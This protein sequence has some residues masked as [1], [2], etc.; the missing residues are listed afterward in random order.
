MNVLIAC[1]CSGI[2]RDAF[3]AKGHIAWSCDLF[4]SYNQTYYHYQGDVTEILKE[5]YLCKCG[6]IFPETF[7]KYGCCSG[8]AKLLTWD[9]LIAFPPCTHLSVSGAKHFKKKI[10]RQ[11]KAID[12]FMQMVTAPIEKI[13]IENPVGIMSTIYRKPDQIIQPYM[14]GD[15][16][17]K[18]TCLWLKG[19]PKLFHADKPDLFNSNITHVDKGPVR[20]WKSGKR[21]ASWFNQTK[22]TDKAT[23]SKLR[24][25]TFPGIANAMAEQW[26]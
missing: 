17:Q 8:A 1:E 7:G 23:T 21:M 14:F 3:R 2:V 13:C 20:V 5:F 9:M 24:S 16:F 4:P 25:I 15:Q 22:H 10:V 12:F 6:N 11:K 18:T 26:G 19:L